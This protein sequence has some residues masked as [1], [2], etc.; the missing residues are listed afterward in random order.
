MFQF[1]LE[2]PRFRSRSMHEIRNEN[3]GR[4]IRE[5]VKE[6]EELSCY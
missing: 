1:Y 6:K 2:K 4:E 5:A 3:Y